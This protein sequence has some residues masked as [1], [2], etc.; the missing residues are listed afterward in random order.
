MSGQLV[1]LDWGREKVHLASGRYSGV[2]GSG[3]EVN[4]LCSRCGGQCE[5]T[6]L[7]GLASAKKRATD[8]LARIID[9]SVERDQLRQQVEGLLAEIASHKLQVEHAPWVDEKADRRLYE[10]AD[11]VRKELGEG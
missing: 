11:Q 4:N 2:F 5:E 3:R 6:S 7:D 8:R 10:F 1:T 9:I